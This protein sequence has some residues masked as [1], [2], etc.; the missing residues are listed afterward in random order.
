VDEIEPV[1]EE[2]S[3]IDWLL[4]DG[5]N[6]TH[7]AYHAQSRNG[8]VGP[9]PQEVAVSVTA[10][11]KR[12]Q[13]ERHVE[14]FRVVVCFD[15]KDGSKWRRLRFPDYKAGRERD[16]EQEACLTTAMRLLFKRLQVLDFRAEAFAGYE[17]DDLIA[18]YADQAYVAN[19]P[20]SSLILSSDKDLLQCLRQYHNGERVIVARPGFKHTDPPTIWTVAKFREEYQFE[21]PRMADYKA[22]VGDKSDGIQGVA[23]IG[24]VAARS[25]LRQFKAGI[26]E[27]YWQDNIERAEVKAHVKAKLR[28]GAADARKFL[29]I[30]SFRKVPGAYYRGEVK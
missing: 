8:E 17:A 4:V 25:L 10:T 1:Q 16:P 5:N 7:R 29:E 23:G 28:E 21:P 24:D 19:K 2:G 11:V 14:P 20:S 15:G 26:S 30:T 6:M 27:I 13:E 22:L 18:T 9:D 12:W 3:A